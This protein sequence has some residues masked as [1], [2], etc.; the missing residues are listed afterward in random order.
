MDVEWGWWVAPATSS[1]MRNVASTS[2]EKCICGPIG[3]GHHDL[4]VSPRDLDREFHVLD[5]IQLGAVR[6]LMGPR[7]SLVHNLSNS[8]VIEAYVDWRASQGTATML[9]GRTYEL[10]G[11][12]EKNMVELRIALEYE[13][14]HDPS[15]RLPQG[16]QIIQ[17]GISGNKPL[18]LE[19][20]YLEETLEIV[21]LHRLG[22]DLDFLSLL[23]LRLVNKATGKIAARMI[24]SRMKDLQLFLTPFYDGCD[25]SGRSV[26]ERSPAQLDQTMAIHYEASRPIEYVKHKDIRLEPAKDGDPLCFVPTETSSFSWDCQELVISSLDRMMGDLPQSEYVGQKICLY[27]KPSN[28]DVQL[29]SPRREF[30]KIADLRFGAAPQ[31]G[32]RVCKIHRSTVNVEIRESCA[33]QVD[34]ITANYKGCIAVKKV[35]LCVETLKHAIELQAHR[36]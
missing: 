31:K 30:M 35:G 27:W 16:L 23:S 25:L 10:Y 15:W 20:Q 33:R 5:S 19:Y 3:F 12:P 8:K 34:E 24:K 21:R 29:L 2:R 4:L 22:E 1:M 17:T 13:R 28:T 9:G 36:R 18:H 26:F 6:V 11:P 7:S 14:I 32:R